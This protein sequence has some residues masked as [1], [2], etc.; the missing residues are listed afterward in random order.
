MFFDLLNKGE[1]PSNNSPKTAKQL[2][3]L[4]VG[5]IFAHLIIVTNKKQKLKKYQLY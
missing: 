2:K 1:V 4:S 5:A 3:I